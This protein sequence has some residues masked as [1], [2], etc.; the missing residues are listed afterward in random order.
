MYDPN[1]S[2]KN[3]YSNDAQELQTRSQRRVLQHK[4]VVF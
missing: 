2:H 1:Y 3:I 4:V